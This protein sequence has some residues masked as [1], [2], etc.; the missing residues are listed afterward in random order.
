MNDDQDIILPLKIEF[1]AANIP[2]VQKLYELI[3][4]LIE[5]GVIR[6]EVSKILD[7]CNMNEIF[8]LDQAISRLAEK[9][10]ATHEKQQNCPCRVLPTHKIIPV[11]DDYRCPHCGAFL[12]MRDKGL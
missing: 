7:R 3:K 9:A 2:K 5:Q 4:T 10:L 8:N 6:P 12:S 11:T 1:D